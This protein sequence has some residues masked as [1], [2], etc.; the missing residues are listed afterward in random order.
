MFLLR[1]YASADQRAQ[2]QN[3]FSR[4]VFP[5]PTCQCS[6]TSNIARGQPITSHGQ[7][8]SNFRKIGVDCVRLS[9]EATTKG[10]NL[11]GRQLEPWG[12]LDERRQKWA[13][14]IS[15]PYRQSNRCD[16]VQ[17]STQLCVQ[18]AWFAQ[19]RNIKGVGMAPHT[20]VTVLLVV[21]RKSLRLGIKTRFGNAVLF[22][23]TTFDYN[24]YIM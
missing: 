19:D 20:A 5:C 14:I 15:S 11:F 18:I 17:A 23:L 24:D 22:S 3:T 2:D 16:R 10:I 4:S 21:L 13:L 1:R 7:W 9:S 6:H 8:D 12:F